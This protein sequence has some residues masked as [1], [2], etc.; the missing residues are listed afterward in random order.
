M[1]VKNRNASQM[2]LFDG[3]PVEDYQLSFKG[4]FTSDEIDMDALAMDDHV[5]LLVIASVG[6]SGFKKTK[7]EEIIRAN[8][9]EVLRA[10]ELDNKVADYALAKQ[11]AVGGAPMLPNFSDPDDP[12]MH[13]VDDDDVTDEVTEVTEYRDV[14]DVDELE[15]FLA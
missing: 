1:G 7:D 9:L 2:E 13:Q 14:G 3:K 5:C 8:K 15:E 10:V 11:A 12:D 6:E 4:T